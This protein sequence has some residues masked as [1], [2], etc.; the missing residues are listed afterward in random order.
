MALVIGTTYSKN[1]SS[2]GVSYLSAGIDYV[3]VSQNKTTNKS[4]IRIFPWMKTTTTNTAYNYNDRTATAKVGS[5][6]KSGKTDYDMREA[7]VNA[8]TYITSSVPFRRISGDFKLVEGRYCFEFDVAHNENGILNDLEIEVVIPSS[9]GASATDSTSTVTVDLPQIQRQNTLSWNGKYIDDPIYFTIT[10]YNDSYTTTIHSL[11]ELESQGGSTPV[12]SIEI[13]NKTTAKSFEFELSETELQEILYGNANSKIVGVYFYVSTYNGDTEI[14]ETKMYGADLSIKQQNPEVSATIVDT[15]ENTISLTG[16]NSIIVKYLSKPKVTIEATAK[17]YANIKSYSTEWGT[18]KSTTQETTFSQGVDSDQLTI[19]A[20]DTRD[21]SSTQTYDFT[22]LNRFIDYIKLVHTK[23]DITKEETSSETLNLDIAGNW[24]NGNFSETNPN[25]LSIKYRYKEKNGEFND[26]Q[27]LEFTIDNNT[28]SCKAEI[29]TFNISKQYSLEIVTSD[30]ATKLTTTFDVLSNNSILR[31]G[32]TY[33]RINGDLRLNGNLILNGIPYNPF[34]Y[35]FITSKNENPKDSIG[36]EWSLVNKEFSS[37]VDTIE[38]NFSD[39]YTDSDYATCYGIAFV[40]NA[41]QITIRI[42]LRTLL[43]VGETNVSL[44]KIN[45]EKFGLTKLP[46]TKFG[47]VASSDSANSIL[48]YNVL[49]TGEINAIDVVGKGETNTISSGTTISI[50][51]SSAMNMGY[52]IDD[53]CNRFI[54]KRT[55]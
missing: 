7:T 18:K 19:K 25:E 2:T 31:V 37:L 48:I 21:W 46:L 54:W 38:E 33:V 43:D 27:P 3:L 51:I 16:D 15:D 9:N 49:T 34:D 53:F 8:K 24:F 13:A 47:M 12:R 22:S 1:G 4:K 35:L 20:T 55:S 32:E 40:R 26:Y 11:W 10:K 23:F 44:G 45:L 28:F 52:M 42:S 36:G 5:L 39:Y 50:E 6:S 14:G 30:K 41:N 29:G 17:Q